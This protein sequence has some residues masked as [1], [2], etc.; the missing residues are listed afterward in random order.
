MRARWGYAIVLALVTCRPIRPDTIT[1]K[2]SLSING[3]IL[4]MSSGA[5]RV[6]V[7]FPSEEKEVPIQLKDVQ[8]IEFNLLTFNP[9]APP[10]VLGFGPPSGA[11][12]T[13]QKVTPAEDVIVLR[14]GTRKS[15]ILVGIDAD[16][17]HCDP[18][19]IGYKRNEVLRVVLGPR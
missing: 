4:G 7:Q 5:L 3:S 13:Q 17:V 10:K 16:R 8:S 11:Q 15:C 12:D 18:N 1:M 14:G 19:D 2:D 6:K 9:G